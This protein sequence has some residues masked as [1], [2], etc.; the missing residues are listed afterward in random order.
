MDRDQPDWT[1]ELEENALKVVAVQ[2]DIPE[3]D[4]SELKLFYKCSD[5]R[6]IFGCLCSKAL[7]LV[8]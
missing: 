3:Q 1:D 6:Q 7:E 5:G 2:K 8:L 4:K